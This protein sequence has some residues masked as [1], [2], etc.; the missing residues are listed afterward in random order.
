MPKF[1]ITFING[2]RSVY[3]VYVRAFN[4]QEAYRKAEEEYKVK[5][6]KFEYTDLISELV[7]DRYG[8]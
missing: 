3:S 6:M 7:G 2:D 8:R 1:R 5:D 4:E